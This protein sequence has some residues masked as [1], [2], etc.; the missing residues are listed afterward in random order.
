MPYDVRIQQATCRKGHWNKQTPSDWSRRD[1]P[2]PLPSSFQLSPFQGLP[3]ALIAPVFRIL[4]LFASF[5]YLNHNFRTSRR[6][7]WLLT[8]RSKINTESFL[9]PAL[10]IKVYLRF[11]QNMSL[12]SNAIAYPPFLGM[13]AE[14]TLSIRDA[15]RPRSTSCSKAT[16][17][18]IH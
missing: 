2:P 15:S 12:P 18:P 6:D 1:F 16:C 10:S 13:S 14:R 4:T 5:S 7:P 9:P 3:P 17:L 11:N 8:G